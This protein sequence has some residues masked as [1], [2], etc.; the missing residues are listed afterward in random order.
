MEKYNITLVLFTWLTQASVGLILLRSVYLRVSENESGAINRKG[1]VSLLIAFI[2]LVAGLLFS[3]GHL[4]Y[5]GHAYNA[6][7]NIGSSW[8]SREILAEIIFLTAVFTW[9]I[10]VRVKIR[11]IPVIILEIISLAA[12]ISLIY[13]MIRTYM[14][15]SLSELNHPSFPLSFIITPLLA[16]SSIMYFL[17]LNKEQKLA[18]RFKLFLTILFIVSFINYIVFTSFQETLSNI[19]IITIF[20]IGGFIASLVSLYSTLKNKNASSDVIFV[21]LAL[22]CDLLN[23]VNALTFTNPAL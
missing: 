7:N 19:N 6:I 16:G 2:M 12:G 22:I 9:Y 21:N 5:P 11:S 4:H 3:F 15:P 23:R 20:Y 17:I 1:T 18:I 13:F 8:M 14:L 10:L